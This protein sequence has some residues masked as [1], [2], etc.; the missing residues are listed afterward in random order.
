MPDKIDLEKPDSDPRCMDEEYIKLEMIVHK[1]EISQK[2]MLDFI[3]TF[4]I[5]FGAGKGRITVEEIA[6]TGIEPANK[7]AEFTEVMNDA[8]V[9]VRSGEKGIQESLDDVQDI[10]AQ[11]FFEKHPMWFVST[12]CPRCGTPN[13]HSPCKRCGYN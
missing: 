1:K 13:I 7:D 4:S 10:M 12:N 2:D 3:R 6:I 11:K 8:N 9:V 5:Y